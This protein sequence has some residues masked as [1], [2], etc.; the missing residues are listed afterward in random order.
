[1]HTLLVADFWILLAALVIAFLGS[2]LTGAWR[3]S[4]R[5]Y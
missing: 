1:M 4:R 3:R 2:L 5:P